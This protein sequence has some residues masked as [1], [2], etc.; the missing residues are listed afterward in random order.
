MQTKTHPLETVMEGFTPTPLQQAAI[1]RIQ[2]FKEELKQY[3]IH[4]RSS[5][6]LEFTVSDKYNNPRRAMINLKQANQYLQ[7][8]EPALQH[9]ETLK[10]DSTSEYEVTIADTIN[11]DKHLDVYAFSPEAIAYETALLKR[12]SLANMLQ[13]SS[14]LNHQYARGGTEPFLPVFDAHPHSNLLCEAPSNHERQSSAL[15]VN[16]SLYDDEGN[17]LFTQS[18]ELMQEAA[19]R[20]IEVQHQAG[21]AFLPNKNSM[22]RLSQQTH[23]SVPGGI[24]MEPSADM[25]KRTFS[26]VNIRGGIYEVGG[27]DAR[28]KYAH[29]T[30]LENRLPGADADPFVAMAVTMA[31]MLDAVQYELPKHQTRAPKHHFAEN[32]REL[33]QQLAAS[34][35]MRELLGTKLYHAILDEYGQSRYQR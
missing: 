19:R 33:T 13:Q 15:H 10:Q 3:G 11:P 2:Y 24:G 9:F 20:L 26:S 12:Q 35:Y 16:I 7:E 5:M 27:A 25:G 23:V 32:R 29:D 1:E 28:I 17:N 8:S 6:E 14:C 4:V 18:P 30:R 21:L 22:A 34:G 31:A